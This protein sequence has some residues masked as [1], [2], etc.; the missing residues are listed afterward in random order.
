MLDR[1]T[2][3]QVLAFVIVTV[4]AVG[5]A[6][7]AYIQLPSVL[8][9]GRYNVSVA[10]PDTG[11][12]YPRAVVSLRGVPVGQVSDIVLN[13][14]GVRADLAIDNG[15]EIPAG[16]DVEVRSVSAIGEQYLNFEPTQS[17]GPTLAAGALVP[18]SQVTLPVPVANL[19]S[20]LN[21]FVGTLPADSLNTTVNELSTGL[22]GTSGDLQRLLDSGGSLLTTADANIDP[23]RRLIDDLQPVLATQQRTEGDVRSFSGDL[24]TF[25]QQL[26]DS[27]PAL[28]GTIEKTPALT[29]EADQLVN[30]IRPT[31]PDLLA[32]LTAVGQ[33]A[34]VYLPNI[35]QIITVLPTTINDMQSV[36]QRAPIPDA[37][38]LNFKAVV[39]D[40]Q[41]CT[42]GFVE[43]QRDPS[44]LSPARPA[45]KAFCDEPADSPIGV[46][47]TRNSPC[48]N[49]DLR[50]KDASGCGLDFQTPEEAKAAEDAGI[51]TMMKVAAGLP[52]SVP[53]PSDAATTPPDVAGTQVS[54]PYDLG[55]G[56]FIGPN[57]KSYLLGGSTPP[58]PGGS[59]WRSLILAPMGVPAP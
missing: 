51:D 10:L 17:A 39:N 56:F 42:Q 28:R 54:T 9:F 4:V 21:G 27:D 45:A 57:G 2:R 25:T 53:R 58:A 59:D 22:T 31:L 34:K 55:T 23:T 48:P 35:A 11:G 29:G 52:T 3:F 36:I 18:A 40:P 33:V 38:Y 7:V 19:L 8:G 44:D 49:G 37:A 50:S 26:R 1:F 13:G 30:Q 20:N 5:Y 43:Q 16:S 12:L 14:T 41:P 47:G 46:R 15:T 32:N 6:S 24:V